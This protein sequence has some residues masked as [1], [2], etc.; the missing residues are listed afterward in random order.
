M[1]NGARKAESKS[2]RVYLPLSFLL[3]CV[4][5]PALGP[6][7]CFQVWDWVSR[8]QNDTQG[9]VISGLLGVI[10]SIGGHFLRSS[11]PDKTY[12]YTFDW[13]FICTICGSGN[14]WFGPVFPPKVKYWEALCR[15]ADNFLC[16][17]R[18]CKMFYGVVSGLLA[19]TEN[20]QGWDGMSQNQ[21]RW[22]LRLEIRIVPIVGEISGK[23]RPTAL[24]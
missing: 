5:F 23:V 12:R 22:P 15:Y 2:R 11:P 18:Y 14:E 7:V 19:W 4:K 17:G 20:V 10:T 24:T 1:D 16:S 9:R 21:K 13:R 6:T 3:A 8:T